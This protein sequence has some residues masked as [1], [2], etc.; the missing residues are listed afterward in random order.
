MNHVWLE[1]FK[2]WSIQSR[3]A[4][5]NASCNNLDDLSGRIY[6]PNKKDV[7]FDVFTMITRVNEAKKITKL[8]SCDCKCKFGGRKYDLYQE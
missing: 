2:T 8:F 7:N 4:R 3:A 1:W 6:V 5:C